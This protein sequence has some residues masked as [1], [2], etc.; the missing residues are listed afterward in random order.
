M[1]ETA[2]CHFTVRDFCVET[3]LILR[4][5]VCVTWDALS[6]GLSP[7]RILGQG[8]CVECQVP[9]QNITVKISVPSKFYTFG[10]SAFKK[11]Q[12]KFGGFQ[13]VSTQIWGYDQIRARNTG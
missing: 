6:L 10:T 8:P 11:F 3:P 12:V 5:E 1:I 4:A 9:L 13:K 7:D 2:K